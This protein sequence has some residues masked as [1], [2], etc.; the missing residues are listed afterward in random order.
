MALVNDAIVNHHPMLLEKRTLC[1]RGGTG[2]VFLYAL[3]G[4]RIGSALLEKM[5]SRPDLI[6]RGIALDKLEDPGADVNTEAMAVQAGR[7]SGFT[8][9]EG[10]DEITD[11]HYGQIVF[12]VDDNTLAATDGG[13]TRSPAGFFVGFDD[14]AGTET[15]MIEV[16]DNF[17]AAIARLQGFAVA[18]R[19]VRGVVAANVA[20]LDA[21]TVAG[22]DGLTYAAGQLLLLVNQTSTDEDG[23][24]VVG[25]VATGVAPLTRPSWWADGS[26]QAAGVEFKVNAGTAWAG[27][28]WY[29]TLAGA[30]TVGTSA[31]AFYPRRHSIV[32]GAMVAGVITPATLWMRTGAAIQH[33]RAAAAGTAGHV[34]YSAATAGKGTGAITLTSSSNTET[35]T[36]AITVFN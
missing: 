10:A 12:A 8:N 34:A 1:L 18:S 3:M 20:D 17:D 2:E 7:I 28:V 5:S 4:Q 16:P 23:P 11:D 27:H 26:V 22:N 9:S 35:S 30:I 24:Y 32:T 25:T 33:A 36:H 6:C 31:P 14:I 19:D 29:A 15:P 21:F 13:G